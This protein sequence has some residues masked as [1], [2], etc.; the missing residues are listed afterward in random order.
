[1]FRHKGEMIDYIEGDSIV[2]EIMELEGEGEF[3]DY[4]DLPEDAGTK[5]L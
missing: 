5:G 2:E 3:Q 1:M 4:G